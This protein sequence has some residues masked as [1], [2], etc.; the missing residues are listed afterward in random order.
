LETIAVYWENKIKTY[1]FQVER[2]LSLFQISMA[3]R[4]LTRFGSVVFNDTSDIQFGWVLVQAS[5]THTL[6]IHILLDQKWE[7]PMHALLESYRRDAK[8]LDLRVK[9]PVEMVFFHGPHFG[10]RYGIADTALG[11]LRRKGLPILIAACTGASV[12]IIV[13]EHR[14][15]EAKDILSDVFDTPQ[16]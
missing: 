4:A 8:G 16:K 11:T 3:P 5:S 14:S 10:D 15:A 2:D 13:P 12:Y 6:E 9:S 7:Q 1:G